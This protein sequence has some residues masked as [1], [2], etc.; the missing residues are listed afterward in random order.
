MAVG[1]S[2]AVHS[3]GSPLPGRW[4]GSWID[5]QT[6]EPPNSPTLSFSM[7]SPTR[8]LPPPPPPKK[9]GLHIRTATCP[10]PGGC[11]AA[12]E[13]SKGNDKVS[14]DLPSSSMIR[15][16]GDIPI[17]DSE[18][19][20]SRFGDLFQTAGFPARRKILVVFIRHFFCGNC[21]EYISYLA[22]S[23][24]SPK[25]LPPNTSVVVIGCGSPSLIPMYTQITGWALPIYTDPTSRIHSIFGLTRTLSLG[26]AAPDY[27]R[28]SLTSLIVRGITQGLKRVRTGDALKSG[29]MLQVGGEFL[30]EVDETPP[31]RSASSS[32]SSLTLL[33]LKRDVGSVQVTWCHRMNHTRDHTEI[34]VLLGILGLEN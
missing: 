3:P 26:P 22:S 16:A 2:L 21:Q 25:S 32:S 18:G 24:P 7:A 27:I 12:L 8:L 33:S 29:D 31:S 28:V 1:N 6:D 23:I 10:L 13:N 34:P 14:N 15:Q 4:K 19:N 30:F 11:G 5:S 9:D 17:F 20:E